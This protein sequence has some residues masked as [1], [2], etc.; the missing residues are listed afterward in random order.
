MVA[1][2]FRSGCP[3]EKEVA[4]STLVPCSLFLVPFSKSI[5]LKFVTSIL[6][7]VPFFSPALLALVKKV[8]AYTPRR[9][10]PFSEPPCPLRC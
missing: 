6:D 4:N 7:E 3:A 2:A 8:A 1:E 10:R 5:R 9:S